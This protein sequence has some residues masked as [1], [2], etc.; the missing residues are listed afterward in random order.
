L[1]G[2][3]Q[4]GSTARSWDALPSSTDLFALLGHTA[5]VFD[6]KFSL[7]G[8]QL[9]TASYDGTARLWDA[10]VGSQ[11][12]T[13]AEHT[14]RLFSVAWSPDAMQVASASADGSARGWGS[15]RASSF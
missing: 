3:V 10:V 8:H 7:D 6:V 5:P 4:H 9:A 1:L 2:Y 12:F 11:L 14:N 13:L 15:G